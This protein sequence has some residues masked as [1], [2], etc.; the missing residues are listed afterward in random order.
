M[1]IRYLAIIQGGIGPDVWDREV[2]ISA[3]DFLDAA[4]QAN[5]KAEELGGQVIILEQYL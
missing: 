3:A 5:A 1:S 2:K 4:N